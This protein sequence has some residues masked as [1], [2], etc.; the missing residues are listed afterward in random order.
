MTLKRII[1]FIG[2]IALISSCATPRSEPTDTDECRK[3]AYGKNSEL[4][5]DASV[6]IFSACMRKK[7]S[8]RETERSRENAHSW[9][10]FFAELFISD[11]D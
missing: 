3:M 7:E 4:L 6:D 2:F 8:L 11:N 10:D 1:F 5:A 9:I